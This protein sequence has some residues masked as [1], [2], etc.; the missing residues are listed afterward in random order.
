MAEKKLNGT[1]IVTY[2]CNARCSMCNRYKAPSKPEEELSIE[3]IKKLP[4]MYFT[5]ITG[6]E[7]FIRTDLPDIVRELYKKSDRIVISTNGYF[8]DRIIALC[9]EF[10]KVGIRISIEGLQATNDAAPVEELL[11]CFGED[12]TDSM[13]KALEYARGQGISVARFADGDVFAMGDGAV[14][15]TFWKNGSADL[16]INN[17]S[18]QTM[19]EYGERSILFTADMERAGQAAL[20]ARIPAERLRADI[21]KYP[22]HGKKTL[23]APFREAVNPRI[24]IVTNQ[25]VDWE[26]VTAMAALNLPT[27]FTNRDGAYLHLVTDGKHWI[28]EYAGRESVGENTR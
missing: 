8:T 17:Q 7:P 19:V 1:V 5:N 15:L 14:S 26:G 9:K 18:A 24:A 28:C 6:G 21:L 10:P 22:H 2:R 27:Y 11:I 12:S 23:Y 25:K 13:I 20:T 3:T 4:K 16:D